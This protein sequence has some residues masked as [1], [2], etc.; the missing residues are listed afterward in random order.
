MQVAVN[1]T[2]KKK[3]EKRN[4]DEAYKYCVAFPETVKVCF[5][6]NR[7]YLVFVYVE[8]NSS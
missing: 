2:V 4:P 3:A 7:N 5:F 8:L 1:Y 6:K